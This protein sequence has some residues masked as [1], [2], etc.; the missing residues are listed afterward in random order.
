MRI[1][2]SSAARGNPTQPPH[3]TTDLT[4]P[5]A[6]GSSFRGDSVSYYDSLAGQLCPAASSLLR[7]SV[8][9]PKILSWLKSK[10]PKKPFVRLFVC[11]SARLLLFFKIVTEKVRTTR[12][13]RKRD[14]TS[15]QHVTAAAAAA[16]SSSEGYMY[17]SQSVLW[18]SA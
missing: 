7:P 6:T 11:L 9:Y 5:T 15:T 4:L 17:E 8:P 16:D 1:E 12:A 10:N 13:E 18:Y 2:T 14:G 3:L